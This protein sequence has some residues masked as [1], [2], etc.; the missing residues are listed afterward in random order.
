M[1]MDAN[2]HR[3]LPSMTEATESLGNHVRFTRELNLKFTVIP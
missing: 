3:K 2:G 1:D